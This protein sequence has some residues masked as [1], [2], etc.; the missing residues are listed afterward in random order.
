[1]ATGD[2]E[3]AALRASKPSHAIA[4]FTTSNSQFPSFL[5]TAQASPTLPAY[6]LLVSSKLQPSRFLITLIFRPILL[7][8]FFGAAALW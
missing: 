5:T 7:L 1:M 6:L 4:S 2:S 3:M 8:E